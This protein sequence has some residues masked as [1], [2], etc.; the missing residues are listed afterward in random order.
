MSAA[1]ARDIQSPTE[2][3]DE[4]TVVLVVEDEVLI[5]MVVAEYLRDCGYVVVEAGSAHEALALFKADVEV[6][7][8]FSDIQM[9]GPMDGFGL[10]QWVRQNKPG[11]EVILTSGAASAADRAAD[12]CEEGPLLQK[13]YESDE[14]DRRIKQLLAA[15]DRN[16]NGGR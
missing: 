12:L 15:R 11:V 16:G 8:V 3:G 9:P 6:D 2:P 13:P 14:V 10:A 7:V 1:A 4:R 5:R